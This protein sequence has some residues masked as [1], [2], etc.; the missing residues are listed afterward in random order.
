MILLLHLAV[1]LNLDVRVGF[2]RYI[3]AMAEKAS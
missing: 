3:V 1:S 2:G